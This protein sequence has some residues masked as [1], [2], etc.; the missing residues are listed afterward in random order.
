MD[1]PLDPSSFL[2]LE[3]NINTDLKEVLGEQRKLLQ[4]KNNSRNVIVLDCLKLKPCKHLLRDVY[5][6]RQ[7]RGKSG[8]LK[9]ATFIHLESLSK[10]KK[11]LFQGENEQTRKD[12]VRGTKRGGVWKVDFRVRSVALQYS[13]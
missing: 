7:V 9:L 3:K 13:V 12:R 6:T 11:S 2:G 4:V 5:L 8:S 1:Q 10:K